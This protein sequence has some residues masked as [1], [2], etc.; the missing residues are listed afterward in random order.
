MA[1]DVAK[2]HQRRASQQVGAGQHVVRLMAVH[3]PAQQDGAQRSAQLEHGA[4]DGGLLQV[5]AGVLQHGGQPA[6]QQVDKEQVQEIDAPQ[7]EAA[8]TVVAVEHD[9]HGALVTF[10]PGLRRQHEDGVFRGAARGT[11]LDNPAD[12][13]LTALAMHEVGERFGHQHRHEQRQHH[14]HHA[15]E[16]EDTLP[17]PV[18]YQP[19]RQEAATGCPHGETGKDDGDQQRT[20]GQG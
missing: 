16:D 5:H 2:Q 6:A 11:A 20:S 3:Q 8:G 10:H 15:A 18:R 17:A 7:H 12:A 4:D 14:G 9:L 19:G 1:T 13:H